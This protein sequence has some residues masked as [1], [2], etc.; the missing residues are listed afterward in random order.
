M[1]TDPSLSDNNPATG[2]TGVNIV[3]LVGITI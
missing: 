1:A 2:R 3:D